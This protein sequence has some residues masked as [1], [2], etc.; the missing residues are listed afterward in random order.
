MSDEFFDVAKREINEELDALNDLLAG[1]KNDHDVVMI[2]PKLQNH[3]HKIMGL[4]PM[5]G[6]DPLGKVAKSTDSLLK[7][8]V[9]VNTKGVFSLL[10][11]IFPFMMSLMIEPEFDSKK[12]NEKISKIE[13]LLS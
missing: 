5:M 2:A 11:E 13:T 3:T 8:L 6:K 10:S 9:D 12:V 4:A 7:K 1:C